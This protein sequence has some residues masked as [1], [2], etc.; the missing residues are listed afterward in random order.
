M[1]EANKEGSIAENAVGLSEV[2]GVKSVW[3]DDLIDND[4]ANERD[5]SGVFKQVGFIIG[6]REET[7]GVSDGIAVQVVQMS[8][9]LS[10]NGVREKLHDE[11]VDVGKGHG[12]DGNFE[13]RRGAA[14]ETEG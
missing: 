9:S 4:L 7:E 10:L 13:N 12:T 5:Q 2:G 3:I 1:V 8:V 11:L 6:I 14:E